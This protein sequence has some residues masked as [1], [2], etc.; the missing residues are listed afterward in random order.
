MRMQPTATGVSSSSFS[1]VML[2]KGVSISINSVHDNG[3]SCPLKHEHLPCHDQ[4]VSEGQP[5]TWKQS[6]LCIG[7][8]GS[9]GRERRGLGVDECADRRWRY[10]R[11]QQPLVGCS[12]IFAA[13]E[14]CAVP[15]S[16]TFC[17]L[18]ATYLGNKA[19]Y[20]GGKCVL[21]CDQLLYSTVVAGLLYLAS[22]FVFVRHEKEI[23][24]AET[25]DSHPF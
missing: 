12:D 5:Q 11:P 20:L 21:H 23:G 17:R 6:T 25:I 22:E 15:R 8:T 10:L 1:R 4:A 3:S 13:A 14:A 16:K 18:C 7:H 9:R 19:R 2:N 24:P